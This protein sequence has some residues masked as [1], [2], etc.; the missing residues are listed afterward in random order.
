MRTTFIVG[1]PGETEEQFERLLAFVEAEEFDHVGVFTYSPEPGTVAADLPNHI[2]SAIAEERRGRIMEAQQKISYRKNRA[3]VGSTLQV[4]IEGVGEIENEDGSS[5]PVA[6]GRARRH[7]PE[8]DGLVFVP[9][10]VPVG[11][12]IDVTITDASPYDLWGAPAGMERLVAESRPVIRRPSHLS[13]VRRRS[14]PVPMA[15]LTGT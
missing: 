12:M 2:P 7:A 4:L 8:V 9:G 11:E 15:K 5:E 10:T 13:K 6:V 1:Y 14:R 3:M